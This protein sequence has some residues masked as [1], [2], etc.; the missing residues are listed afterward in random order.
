MGKSWF[1]T[2]TGL[3]LLHSPLLFASRRGGVAGFV[4]GH[5]TFGRIE[6]ILEVERIATDHLRGSGNLSRDLRTFKIRRTL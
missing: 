4:I 6:V 2:N 3:P 1:R 5:E